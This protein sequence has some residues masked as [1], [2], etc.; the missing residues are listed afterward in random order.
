MSCLISTN[1]LDS[2]L[3]ITIF[4]SLF[5]DRV[6]QLVVKMLGHDPHE[7]DK[8]ECAEIFSLLAE[9]AEF[10]CHA[11][12]GNAWQNHLL[13]LMIA[14]DNVF[15]RKAE[16]SG[17]T[18]IG[19]SLVRQMKL[20][21]RALRT[22]HDV[23]ISQFLTTHPPL[24]GFKAREDKNQDPAYTAIKTLLFENQDWR[25]MIEPLADYFA[26]NGSGDF[27]AYRAFRWHNGA[28]KGV[29]SPDPVRFADLLEYDWQRESVKRN[30]EK[31]LA[32]LPTNNLLLYGDRGT[33][34]SSTVKSMLNEFWESRLRIVEV[35][36]ESLIE[37]PAILTILRRRPEKFI[38]FLDD[39]S[40]EEDET[41]YKA[42]KAVLEGGLEARPSNVVLYSTSN[43][44]NLIREQFSDRALVIEDDEVH[45]NDTMQEKLSLSDRFGIKLPFLSPDQDEFLGMVSEMAARAGIEMTD[46]IRKQALQWQH[47]RSGRS[48]RQ[49]V[50]YIIGEQALERN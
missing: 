25:N 3:R 30:T 9:S 15:A 39:L 16:L 23:D 34:K 17:M 31:L 32:N 44:R 28:L 37:L 18:L 6:F 10:S 42:L 20:D 27:G 19:D 43:R 4:R 2:I 36:K 5:K 13:N 33:G 38:L 1:T 35:S 50:D 26:K 7:C 14:D 21:L 12:I 49:F 40:F 24:D 11:I 46:D 22:L 29:E 41:Q 8:S 45:P 48:A 47:A